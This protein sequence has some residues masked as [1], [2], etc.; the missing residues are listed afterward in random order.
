MRPSSTAVVLVAALASFATLSAPTAAHAEE[1]KKAAAAPT[2]PRKDP[3]GLTGVSPY[4]EAVAKGHALIAARDL[5]G[6][7]TAYQDAI[8]QDPD[9]PIGHYFLG[10]ARVMKNELGEATASLESAVRFAGKNEEIQGKAMFQ[11]ADVKER[12]D[13]LDEAKKAWDAYIQFVEAH[14]KAHGFA[15]SGA[16]RIKAADKRLAIVKSAAEVKARIEQRLKEVGAPP[17]DDGPQGPGSG[18]KKLP[19]RALRRDRRSPPTRRNARPRRHR[20]ASVFVFVSARRA[21][22]SGRSRRCV[23]P[24]RRAPGSLRRAP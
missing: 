11:L 5:A 8:S 2:G 6:A 24:A 7:V 13:K 19:T 14:P 4:T 23:R 12:Q 17:P 3:K 22:T 10:A 1:T 9:N 15:Q 21:T 16:E 20:G 18:K